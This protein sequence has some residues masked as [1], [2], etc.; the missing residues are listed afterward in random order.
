MARIALHRRPV[1]VLSLIGALFFVPVLV[2]L[3]FNLPGWR[4]LP[5]GTSNHGTLIR[6][7]VRLPGDG[8]ISVGAA[9][10]SE[11]RVSGKW[12][13]MLVA[14]PPC[15]PRCER[16]LA[17]LEQVRAALGK[18]FDRT[19]VVY[20]VTGPFSPTDAA[21]LRARF[22][23]LVIA[24]PRAATRAALGVERS[25]K[26]MIALVDPRRYFFMR[27]PA[28]VPGPWLVKDMERVLRISKVD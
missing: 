12:I 15:D 25:A 19:R 22:R 27:Y 20:L 16:V 7:A 26:P 24:R 23:S 17:K 8:F 2:A 3:L 13:M 10:S 28:G 6:P 18:D 9:T 11:P 21:V 1:V 5:F 4:W 14:A